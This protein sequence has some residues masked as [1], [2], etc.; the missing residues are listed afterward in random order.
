MKKI[1]LSLLACF[2]V[3]LGTVNASFPVKK[4][5]DSETVSETAATEAESSD[6]LNALVLSS[7]QQ[8]DESMGSID[9]A[10]AVGK[11]SDE[12]WILLALWFFLGA[13]AAHRWY[14]GK[15]V[16]WN[17]LYILTLGGC[18]VWAILPKPLLK[19]EKR[20]FFLS[21][22]GRCQGCELLIWPM[23]WLIGNLLFDQNFTGLHFR[24]IIRKTVKVNSL[25]Q[26]WDF[27]SGFASGN[28]LV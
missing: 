22:N 26:V 13:F 16:G 18:G 9:R 21:S 5:N 28:T 14:A 23:S 8:V 24:T 15:P 10:E 25:S 20:L 4:T 1:I 19:N 27:H 2:V 17:I 11:F 12:D 7:Q 6:N 3:A